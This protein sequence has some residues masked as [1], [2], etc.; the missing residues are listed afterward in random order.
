MMWCLQGDDFKKKRQ[1]E[2]GHSKK[3]TSRDVWIL[4]THRLKNE[5]KKSLETPAE[6]EIV[7]EKG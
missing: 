4:L 5:C 6:V 7:H 2:R 3:S 1:T